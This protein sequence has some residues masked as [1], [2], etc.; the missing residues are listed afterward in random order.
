MTTEVHL[1]PDQVTKLVQIYDDT[2]AQ[3]DDVHEKLEEKSRSIRDDQIA[4]IKAMLRPDQ[5]PLYNALHA[6]HEAE[7]AARNRDKGG[8]VPGDKS[9]K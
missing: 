4:K 5:V 7:R 3:F 9:S 6:R 1:D 2:K 8:I